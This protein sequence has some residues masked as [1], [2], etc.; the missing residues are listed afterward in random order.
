[1]PSKVFKVGFDI[2]DYRDIFPQEK[3]SEYQKEDEVI[4]LQLP[5]D[6]CVWKAEEDPDTITSEYIQR[7][8]KRVLRTGVWVIIKGMAMWI[9]P[10]YYFFLRYFNT[11]VGQ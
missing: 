1:M 3:V 8:V 2:L 5:D 7:E 10:N 4:N 9:P 6:D 11:G